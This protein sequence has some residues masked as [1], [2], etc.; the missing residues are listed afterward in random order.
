MN[1]FVMN[2]GAQASN[3][4]TCEKGKGNHFQNWIPKLNESCLV[5]CIDQQNRAKEIESMTV[6][7]IGL[8]RWA[9]NSNEAFIKFLFWQKIE[10]SLHKIS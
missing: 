7:E 8:P 1:R 10:Q 2:R 5:S 6:A 3:R 9:V 4:K